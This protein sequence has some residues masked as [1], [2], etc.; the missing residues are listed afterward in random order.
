MAV[1]HP[2]SEPGQR[3]DLAAALTMLSRDSD[4]REL[5]AIFARTF[6]SGFEE[7]AEQILG[8]GEL[9]KLARDAFD[10]VR[11][12]TDSGPKIT[13]RSFPR[14]SGDARHAHPLTIVEILNDDMPFLVS[15]V[16]GEVQAR[17]LKPRI[18]LHPILKVRRDSEGRLAAIDETP[19]GGGADGRKE[20]FIAI[21][22]DALETSAADQLVAALGEVLAEVRA[23]V[24][25]WKAMLARFDAAIVSL[26]QAP[27]SVPR[28][29]L[30]ETIDLCR[31]LRDGQLTFL[32]M[33]EYRL[34]GSA[35]TGELEV[36]KGSGLGILRNP[37]I[38]VL[39]RGKELVAMTPEV[40]RFYFAPQPIIITKSNVV[41]RVHR[42]VHMDYIGIKTY[43]AD[44]T[45]AG[46]LR[47]V[48]LLTAKAYTAPPQQ[49]PFLRLKV[50]RVLAASGV[51]PSSHA[52]RVLQNIL[53]TFPRDE[54]IQ[55]GVRQLTSWVPALLD[56]ELRPRLRVFVRTDRFDRFVS[57]LVYMPR[58]GYTTTTREVIGNILCEAFDGRIS[59]YQPFFTAGPLVRVHFIIGRYEGVT[60]E[61]PAS[62][63]EHR[64]REATRTW[65]DRLQSEILARDV[66]AKELAARYTHAF[67][68]G[69]AETFAPRRALEDI[70]RIERLGPD[71]PQAIDF[72]PERD[73][74]ARVRSAIYRFDAPIPLSERV[75][76]LENLGFK[77]I[78]E[79]T[80]RL[81][82]VIDG[83]AR[84]VCL[85]DMVLESADAAPVDI[86]ANEARLEEAFLAVFRGRAENDTF[87]RLVLAAGADWR[88][89]A[90]MRALAGYMRQIRSPFGARYVADTLSAHAPMARDLIELFRIRF[91]PARAHDANARAA[92]QAAVVARFEA[93]LAGVASLDEDRILRQLLNLVTAAQRTNFY[94]PGKDGALPE[95]IAIKFA[96]HDIEGAPE[97]RPYREIW[98]S[99]P[100][101]DGIHLRFAPIARGGLRWSDRPHDVRTEV[102]GLAKA[103]QVKNTVIVPQGAKGGFVPK[104]LPRTGTREEI[105]REGVAA[106]RTFVSTLLDVTDNLAGANVVPPDAVVRHDE[107]DPYLV[108][109][110]DKGT[111]TFSDFAN[112]ISASHGFWLDDAFAS[113]GSAGY[114]HKKMGI[115]AR[116]A[117]ECVKRHFREMDHDVATDPF[118]VIGVGDM[119]GDVF[120]NGM[121]LSRAIRLVAAFDHRDIFLDPDPDPELSFAERQRLFALPRSSW[122]D[123]DTLKLSKGGGVFSRGAKSVPLSDEVRAMLAIDA[124][125]LP[126]AE[127]MRAILKAKVDLAWFGGIGTYV[128]ATGETDDQVGDRA[129]DQL[130]V[131]ASEFGARVV[132][133]GANLA[134]TQRARIEFASRG[135]RLN[136]DFIDNSAGVN[137]SDQEVNIKIALRPAEERGELDRESRNQLLATMTDEVAAAC[138]AN[139]HQQSLALSLEERRGAAG[140]VGSSTLMRVLEARGLL[141][142]KLEALPDDAEMTERAAAGVGLTRPEIAVLLSYAK[143]ALSYDLIA[144]N[145]PDNPALQQMLVGYFPRR[146]GESYRDDLLAHKLRRE[147]ITTELTN[148]IINRGGPA[149]VVTL[150]EETGRGI[151]DV[152]HAFIAADKVFGTERL[153]RAIDALDGRI[154]GG[155]QLALYATVSRLLRSHTAWFAHQDATTRDLDA[156]IRHHAAVLGEVA[157]VLRT[158][159]DASRTAQIEESSA[160]YAANGVPAELARDL[161]LAGELA[162]SPNI[163]LVVERTHASPARTA[164]AYFSITDRLSIG[165]VKSRGEALVVTDRFEKMAI[166]RAIS[167]IAHG[168][169]VLTLAALGASGGDGDI[170]PWLTMHRDTIAG[171]QRII[172][173]ILASG[174]MTPARLTVAAGEVA[175]LAESL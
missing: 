137:S 136:T 164:A 94:Q 124:K 73:G 39:R 99:S 103:Q 50:R 28:D 138:L 93:A 59:A 18:A 76:I 21:V 23:A 116:G 34:A 29:I 151:S 159:D 129:N 125:A 43:H 65:E 149:F 156:T 56:L 79:R 108:V 131:T 24:G 11:L 44:G 140:L 150:M 127:L 112:E 114:D 117:W 171:A 30:N 10:F 67:S 47:I 128:K 49:I 71:R 142:R 84:R 110:A 85:H 4:N 5:F 153:W 8:P 22:L 19:T 101:V 102:L 169:R 146:L 132:G 87:N 157:G 122:Q 155:T 42:R 172:A 9:A 91:D 98:V 60:P 141:D 135:G 45:L 160:G 72:Y 113:G 7:D 32:G 77:V 111:A 170:S 104:Q 2:A 126:P 165:P 143:L 89:A 52:H 51:Q 13:A 168:Q 147:I 27:E 3:T 158:L 68:A 20:S 82:P 54:L 144:S 64:I 90:V 17:G 86:A 166:D 121:L 88:E 154:A 46:E 31:W 36:V 167:S 134:L 83:N 74:L 14:S 81:S 123:Y 97:P 6:F 66:G 133:E 25:D 75:P 92:A 161:A 61:V 162:E 107:D 163:A 38:H 41:S 96:S 118:R 115:T 53:D 48:G 105:M 145:V 148:D 175:N 106:Y 15:S 173:D 12:R 62:E 119:S 69:Y 80:Y 16:M 26:E 78:D 174:E 95:A 109:A 58:D 1:D 33:R 100:R 35:E 57:V 70:D 40:R 55:V 37:D 152:A 120:G 130:R 63:L 139:N